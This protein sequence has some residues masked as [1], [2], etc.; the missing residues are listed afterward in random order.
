[1]IKIAL[2]YLSQTSAVKNKLIRFM[3][4][5]DIQVTKVE[6]IKIRF[7]PI[8]PTS[9]LKTDGESGERHSTKSYRKL[10]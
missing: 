8:F 6:K 9:Y 4:L 2:A 10:L 1:M 7:L 3:E 5:V